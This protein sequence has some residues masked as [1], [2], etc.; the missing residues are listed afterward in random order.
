MAK[1]NLNL[2]KLFE[3]KANNIHH[4]EVSSETEYDEYYYYECIQRH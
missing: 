3:S 2:F 1:F 4:S